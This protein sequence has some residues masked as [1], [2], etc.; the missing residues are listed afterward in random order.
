MELPAGVTPIDVT[1]ECRHKYVLLLNV[2]LYGLKQAGFN[3][4]KK[5]GRGLLYRNF[6]Q[7]QVDK[8]IIF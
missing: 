1:D 8:S 2:S 5:L 4:F 6:I 7:S 3:W